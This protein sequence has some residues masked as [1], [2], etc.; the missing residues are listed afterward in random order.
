[1][2]PAFSNQCSNKSWSGSAS[3]V[4][5]FSRSAISRC[6]LWLWGHLDCKL[7]KDSLPSKGLSMHSNTLCPTGVSSIRQ[8]KN[9]S[10]ICSVIVPLFD[11]DNQTVRCPEEAFCTAVRIIRLVF[12]WPPF[13]AIITEALLWMSSSIASA[14]S[15]CGTSASALMT[16]SMVR[17][18]LLTVKKFLIVKSLQEILAS[19]T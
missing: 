1:M 16:S 5:L 3:S 8:L 4:S 13:P 19:V 9:W 6:I 12:P 11:S 2:S 18:L 15:L 7:A 17:K 14:A 10:A